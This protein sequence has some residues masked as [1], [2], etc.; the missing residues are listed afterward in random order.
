MPC[1]YPSLG[2]LEAELARTLMKVTVRECPE[3]EP[4]WK[5]REAG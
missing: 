4:V 1:A 2:S 3:E 5:A